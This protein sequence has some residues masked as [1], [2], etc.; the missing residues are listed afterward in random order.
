[1]L[2][3]Y[4][5]HFTGRRVGAIGAFHKVEASRFANSPEEAVRLLYEPLPIAFEHIMHPD[6]KEEKSPFDAEGLRLA[7]VGDSKRHEEFAH[8]VA[9][10]TAAMSRTARECA[11]ANAEWHDDEEGEDHGLYHAPVDA[12][13]PAEVQVEA[14]AEVVLYL[15]RATPAG[16]N[17]CDKLTLAEPTPAKA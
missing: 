15:L 13:Y 4:S 9:A 16:L 5:I 3:A 10:M 1:M 12:Q 11:K 2:K 17:I 7:I 14:I 6:V 8:Y